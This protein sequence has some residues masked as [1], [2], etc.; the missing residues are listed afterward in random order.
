MSYLVIN[1]F[2][3][4][5]DT[6]RHILTS[7]PGSVVK[8]VNA[9]ITRGGEIEKRK[10]FELYKTL[11]AGTFG[12]ESCANK[13]YTFG[14]A[15]LASQV[16]SGITYQR[17][18]HPDGIF[19]MTKVVSF[20]SYNGKTFVIAEFSDGNRYGYY[21]TEIISDFYN[22]VS[23]ASH[24][25]IHGF[26]QSLVPL[27]PSS[28]TASVVNDALVV[29]GPLGTQ[30]SLSVDTGGTITAG[31]PTNS[32]EAVKPIPEVKAKGSFIVSGGS[33]T[34][35]S[36]GL[37]PET[38][39]IG[40]RYLGY[41]NLPGIVGLIVGGV[42]ILNISKT[43][44]GIFYN[45]GPTAYG[46]PG[47]KLSMTMSYFINLN[48][49]NSKF[50]SS[51]WNGGGGWS[52]RDP[53]AWSI[54]GD[55]NTPEAQNGDECWLEVKS[56]PGGGWT[57]EMFRNM[58]PIPSTYFAP[59]EDPSIPTGRYMM[60]LS[61]DLSGGYFSGATAV[62]VDG[63]DILGQRTVWSNSNSF[64]AQTIADAINGYTSEPEYVATAIDGGKVQLTAQDGMGSSINGK[65]VN[66]LSAGTLTI[67][68]QTNMS[69]GVDPIGGIA[70][71]TVIP[72]AGNFSPNSTISITITETENPENP[73]Y[74]GATRLGGLK[75]AFCLTFKTKVHVLAES[76]L[77]SSGLDSPTGWKTSDLGSSFIDMSN[78]INGSQNLVSACSYQGKMAIFT[79]DTCQI[80]TIDVDAAN[81]LQGQVILNSGCLAPYSVIGWGEVDVFYMSDSGIRSLRARDASN[82]AVVNDIGT[83]VDSEIINEL[84]AHTDEEVFLSK[85]IIEPKDGR[86]MITIG[87]HLYVLSQFP[88]SNILAW[89][90]YEPGFT[91]S[92]MCVD[93][94][95]LYIRST[96]NKIYLYGGTDGNTYDS[97]IVTVELPYLDGTKP[98]SQKHLQGIDMTS[99]GTWEFYAGT[100]TYNPEVRD[101]I[102]TISSPTMQMGRIPAYGIGTHIGIKLIGIGS[103]Y[104]RVANIIVHYELNEA[105]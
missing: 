102:A 20:T 12:L 11:P 28:Y 26:L 15:D 30:F 10:I 95:K 92:N 89:S 35:A 2:V 51:Y 40:G 76:Y 80:W 85:S 43:G 42:D 23:R 14:S 93:S 71:R 64:T 86:L 33:A 1:N 4:G 56:N 57:S 27:F 39:G 22:G 105:D 101:F 46:D 61:K 77:I 49:G 41:E 88:S 48:T 55:P 32:T 16:P 53:G 18:Q 67:S 7:K 38:S 34:P 62:N 73:I 31:V 90:T 9:H 17:L 58:A 94:G 83:P 6:R 65:I 81:N 54:L 84:R 3:G 8:L 103:G 44:A 99:D 79:R 47:Q 104:C 63:V 74:V 75:P 45:S 70:Q 78:N 21:N 24:A 96:D 29:V 25:S 68:T 98:A 97:S 5:L 37:N 19:P 59:G 36:T 72:F 50:T 13:L 66:V 52:G 60:R 87:E 69:G 91:V 82:Q 100:D